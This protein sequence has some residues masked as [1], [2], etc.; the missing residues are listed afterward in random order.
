MPQMA[1]I[2]WL[3]LFCTFFFLIYFLMNFMF[4]SWAP[5]KTPMSDPLRYTMTL[6]W[7]W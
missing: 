1:P 6:T 7:K 3:P 5:E 2:L 4:F